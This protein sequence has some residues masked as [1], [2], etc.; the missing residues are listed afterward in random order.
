MNYASRRTR[1][2]EMCAQQQID[3]L[4]VAPGPNMSYLLGYH[5]HIDER[6][7]YLLL[8]KDGEMLIVPEL[9]ADE[10]RAHVDLPMASYSDAEGPSAALEGAVRALGLEV[11]QH[12]MV[13]ESMRYDFV[14]HLEQVMPQATFRTSEPVL[15]LAR[16]CKD[17]E[18]LA[19]IRHN[20]AMAD[21]VMARVLASLRPGMTE[22]EVA[23]LVGELFRQ[24]GADRTNFAIIG[25]GPNSAFPHHASG[26]RR[27]APGDAVVVDIGAHAAGYNSD[28]TR[29]AYLGEPDPTYRAVHATVEA[30]VQA[31][32]G[33][34]RPG[35]P[36]RE[37]DRAARAVI[38]EA[39]YGPYFTHRVGH[40]LG[41]TGH[42][43]PFLT[44][45]NDLSLEVGMTFSV[46]PGIYLPGRFGV[47][48]EEIVVVTADGPEVL[49]RLS[50]EVFVA[51]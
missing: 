42:E 37:V 1:L 49:S 19:A 32:L 11:A 50:R 41:V 9:N 18:E 14:R 33:V 15:A 35:V 22:S 30:A 20:A 51:A 36:A 47:R 6:P 12:A 4:A 26:S 45:A 13:E 5:P 23:L 38:A 8:A 28:I 39:G 25:S 48:L 29:M 43:P 27:L 16:M 7:C 21:R 40:G 24:E 31:A 2:R 44:A 10:V 3:V 46:E 17:D 34:I